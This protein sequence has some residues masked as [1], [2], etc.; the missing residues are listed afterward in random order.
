MS[1]SRVQFHKSGLIALLLFTVLLYV[2]VLTVRADGESGSCGDRL[3]WS[4]TEGTLTI[5]GE[6][7]MWD[8]Q[9]STM[10]PW[11]EIRSEIK[12]LVL[13]KEISYI[14][15]LAFYGCDRLTIA[16]LPDQ[17]EE[18]GAF[19]FA[20]CKKL[21][22]LDLG[23]ALKAIHNGAFYGCWELKDVSFPQSLEILE[24]QAF[25]DCASLTS[26]VIPA[27]VQKMGAAVFAYCTGLVRAEIRTELKTLPEW[28]FFGCKMLDTLILP[29]TIT[30][31]ENAALRECDNLNKVSYGGS[32]LTMEQLKDAITEDVPDFGS[33]G[34]VTEEK[35]GA[36]A[37]AGTAF[38]ESDGSIR[39]QITTVISSDN[40]SVGATQD[41]TYGKE[42][43]DTISSDIIVTIEKEAGWEEAIDGIQ[44]VIDEMHDRVVPGVSLGT[45][46]VTIYVKEGQISDRLIEELA[47]SNVKLTIVSK[48]GSSWILDMNRIHQN[49]L[50]GAYDLRYS[51]VPAEEDL[52]ESLGAK[53]VYSLRFPESA[54]VDAEV[55]IQLPDSAAQKN[56]TLFGREKK[57]DFIR[58]Q[59]VLVDAEGFA[60]LYLGSV[61]KD[62]EY[63]LAID[64][65]VKETE[66][67]VIPDTII[68]DTM[69]H[70]Y[71]KMDYKEPI[72][73]EI[74]GRS[75]SWGMNL[76][77]VMG[78]LAA[79]MVGVIIIVGASVY[80]LNKR[81]V[82]NGYVAGWD[83]MDDDDEE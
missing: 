1:R 58:Y 52:L 29:D 25:Y 22:M 48:D 18:I 31:M 7:P 49:E 39:E 72:R 6:G 24:E 12:T 54:Q 67:E 30:G 45:T 42:G 82:R 8:F 76:G 5:E 63:Y 38:E 35:P 79:V 50:S 40:A 62:T 27:G 56:A 36:S 70:A 41:R 37:S 77:Q 78:I 26:I 55:L 32:S 64:V 15:E 23:D 44:T 83:D 69:E 13:T 65:S 68:P 81:R 10:A 57:G 51:I 28:T 53:Q 71:P 4:F 59:S 60:H 46:N 61:D 73:Y 16:D 43:G 3:T 80:G 33:I 14:G 66:S 11:Y 34:L 47:G 21:T 19:A 75:S 17:V 20:G 2:N 9:E 74:T